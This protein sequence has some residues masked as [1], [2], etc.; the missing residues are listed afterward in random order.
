MIHTKSNLSENFLITGQYINHWK[1]GQEYQK[2]G[3]LETWLEVGTLILN[4]DIIEALLLNM[5]LIPC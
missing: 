1:R 4:M 2:T 5:I 3:P